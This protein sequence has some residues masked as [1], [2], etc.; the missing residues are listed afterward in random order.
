MARTKKTVSSKKTTPAKKTVKKVT[1]TKKVVAKK[2]Q[3]TDK[4]LL[5][6]LLKILGIV[7]FI[8]GTLALLDLAVQYLNNDYSIAVVNGKRI[9]KAEWHERLGKAYGKSIAE[10]LINDSI[11]EKE[12]KKGDIKIEKEEIQKQIETIKER[13]GGEDA[14]KAALKANNIELSDLEDQLRIDTLYNKIIGPTIKYTDDDLK[15]FFNQYS[16]VMFQAETEALKEGEKLD[17]EKFKEQVEKIYIEQQVQD[18][19]NTWLQER[20]GEY[21][22]QDNTTGK[23]KYGIFTV[24]RNLVKKK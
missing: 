19:K 11:V 4:T 16:N 12:A 24:L 23:P 22:I 15:N 17:Y 20:K 14:F 10:S 7:V 13:I 5:K 9:T 21:K 8:V 2:V 3:T 18:Q 1:T 6:L